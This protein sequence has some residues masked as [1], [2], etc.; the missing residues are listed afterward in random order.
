M[1]KTGSMR[2]HDLNTCV[3]SVS[4]ANFDLFV[5]D[6]KKLTKISYPLQILHFVIHMYIFLKKCYIKASKQ[7][8][9][10]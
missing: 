8:M 10:G 6:P 9:K 1:C 4:R 3:L 5:A 2:N 7:I